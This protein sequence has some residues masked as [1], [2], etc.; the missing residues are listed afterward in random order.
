MRRRDPASC[1]PMLPSPTP[2]EHGTE[3]FLPSLWML[4]RERRSQ[5]R[6]PVTP[7]LWVA[8]WEPHSS[9]NSQK[10]WVRLKDLAIFANRFPTRSTQAVV[11]ISSLL[12]C[13]TKHV[14]QSD[15]ATHHRVDLPLLGPL[16]STLPSP[17]SWSSLT[18][19][20]S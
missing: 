20:G 12:T 9:L 19:A 15:L 7:A 11:L 1:L 13:G 14:A 6:Y 18:Q 10:L 2:A 3:R 17:G 4:H 8:S 5:G 16:I